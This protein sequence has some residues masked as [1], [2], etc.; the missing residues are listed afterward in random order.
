MEKHRA[1]REGGGA[2]PAGRFL[3][4]VA[5][6]MATSVAGACDSPLAVVPDPDEVNADQPVPLP[7][8][9]TGATF[10][11]FKA[12]DVKVLFSGLLGD[13][14]VNSGTAL[15]DWDR[16]DVDPDCCAG[17]E[18]GQS[19]G[20][21]NYVPMQRAVRVAEIAQQRI[22]DGEFEAIEEAPEESPE[23]ARVSMYSGFARVW[24]A[25]L[26]CTLAFDGTGPEL[27][28]REVYGL[29]EQEFTQAIEADAVD[30]E[31][32][33]AALVGRAR[34][35]LILGDG[36]GASSD[37]SQV[38]PGFEFRATFS[39]N[40]FEQRNRVW[41]HTWQFRNWS[42]AP[43]FRGLTIDDTGT[44]DPR[45]DLADNPADALDPSQELFTPFKAQRPTS[46]LVIASGDEAQYILAE[47]Q[48]G[49]AAVDIINEVRQRNG[50]STEWSPTGDDPNEI[51][52]K[53]IEERARTLFLEG[54]HLGDLR[55]Y[56]EKYDLDLFPTS[57]PQG[58]SMGD[59]TCVPLPN[60][61]RDNNPDI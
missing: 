34:V 39:T 43:R 6:A 47:V 28:S 46:P 11:L 30:D 2:L 40:T 9:M 59:Q 37:A 55:R 4:V 22:R 52:D 19:L 60:V 18:R 61:E 41:Y 58:F 33:Q 21:P 16:R 8:M 49:S 25:D 3:L 24:L 26:F 5:V 45:V 51:R 29:A 1:V 53:L 44:P 42:V 20:S 36:A 13:E 54:V 57:T 14:F 23:F 32:R 31:V 17:N 15:Q 50:I 10:D 48:G 27:T 7:Q 35:R 38:E 56:L 12:Y